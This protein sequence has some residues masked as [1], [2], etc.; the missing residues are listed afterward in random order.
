MEYVYGLTE[1]DLEVTDI[2][3]VG[4]CDNPQRRLGEHRRSNGNTP[5]EKKIRELR[6]AG[7]GIRMVILG[8]YNTRKEAIVEENSWI[9]FG[10]NRKWNLV[11]DT[12]QS[13][14]RDTFSKRFS[15]DVAVAELEKKYE[16]EIVTVKKSF[17]TDHKASIVK[18]GLV[19]T[20][21]LLLFVFSQSNKELPVW[22][23]VLEGVIAVSFAWMFASNLY[24]DVDRKQTTKQ[25]FTEP[26][27]DNTLVAKQFDRKAFAEN[28]IKSLRSNFPGLTDGMYSALETELWRQFVLEAVTPSITK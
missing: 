13:D 20:A 17:S 12:K 14:W 22:V 26:S 21:A 8:K 25:V 7:K 15:Y 2:F 18:L 4:R 10:R 27:N 23:L 16:N 19:V 5:K 28:Y 24:I 3:Y 11:N 6:D 9:A 1:S